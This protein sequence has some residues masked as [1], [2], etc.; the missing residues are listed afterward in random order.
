MIIEKEFNRRPFEPVVADKDGPFL[1]QWLAACEEAE[2]LWQASEDNHVVGRNEQTRALTLEMV[3]ASISPV[4]I[5]SATLSPPAQ[6]R[7]SP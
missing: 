5:S 6:K 1:R 3:R 7:R 2:Q 4:T